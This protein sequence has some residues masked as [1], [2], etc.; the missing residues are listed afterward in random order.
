MLSRINLIPRIDNYLFKVV[1]D[2][3]ISIELNI[4]EDR[5]SNK[6]RLYEFP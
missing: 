4:K 5:Y 1:K 3:F 6:S 2:Y